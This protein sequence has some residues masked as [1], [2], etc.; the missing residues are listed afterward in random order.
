MYVVKTDSMVP[1]IDVDTVILVH[2]EDYS[3]LNKGEV[4]TFT[5]SKNTNIP[6]THRIVGYYYEYL[7]GE[8][9]KYASSYDYNSISELEAA[10]PTYNVIGYRTKGDNPDCEIDIKPVMFDSIRGVYQNNLVVITF[11]FGLLSNFF[12]FLLII[13]V[14]LFVLL[15]MQLISM[16]KMRQQN[17]LEK[18][19]EES[20]KEL[21]EKIKEEAIKEY[22]KKQEEEN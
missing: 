6:N 17:K 5:F 11:L 16:Y 21:E 8:E 1:T 13:L 3:N 22:L 7:D 14:P 18:E 15:I 10:N 20:K 19:V 9:V 12:G 4:I 2:E